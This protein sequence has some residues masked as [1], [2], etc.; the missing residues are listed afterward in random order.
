MSYPWHAEIL[1]RTATDPRLQSVLVTSAPGQ[2][3]QGFADALTARWMC[4]THDVCGRCKGCLFMAQE[5]H[6]DVFT[7][8]P[9]GA[10]RTHRIEAIRNLVE[11]SV[12][13]TH[14]GGGR[15]IRIIEAERM[16]IAAA[17]A[18]LKLLE[19][20]PRG[21]RFILT[22]ERPGRLPATILSRVRKLALPNLTDVDGWL[23]STFP[24]LDT[25]AARRVSQAPDTLCELMSEP[26]A[27]ADRDGWRRGLMDAHAGEMPVSGLVPLVKRMDPLVWFDDWYRVALEQLQR[28]APKGQTRYFLALCTFVERLERERSP[29]LRQVTVEA[30]LVIRALGDLW[31]RAGRLSA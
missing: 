24:G 4:A 3:V 10:S 23:A 14:Q 2:G 17:N 25:S 29:A 18:L 28:E 27:L 15:V 22:T 31:V 13:T 8:V 26:D 16:N 5:A 12:T 21:T 1:Q 20:P 30:P 11:S 6:P 19:E 9:D 7:L